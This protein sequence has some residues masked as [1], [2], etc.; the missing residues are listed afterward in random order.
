MTLKID[1]SFADHSY[2]IGRGGK[3]TKM[4]M[5]T[6]GTNV[7]FP[8]ANRNPEAEKSNQVCVIQFEF[9]LDFFFIFLTFGTL[10]C[11]LGSHLSGAIVDVVI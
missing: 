2:I 4:V 1:V 11:S 6:T 3:G 10:L 7:H 9:A 5:G 8:D